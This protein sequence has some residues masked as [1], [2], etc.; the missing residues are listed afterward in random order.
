MM[1]NL[2]ARLGSPM[3]SVALLLAAVDR[4]D[5]YGLAGV[6]LT[7]HAFAIAAATPAAG[8]LV[9]KYGAR[10][11]IAGGVAA[12]TVAY[13]G[14]LLAFAS[15]SPVA[16]IGAV[17]VFG[18]TTPPV[19]PVTRGVLPRL[20]GGDTLVA[21][22]ALDSAINEVA[23]VV[24]PLLVAA[25]TTAVSAHTVVI[26]AGALMLVAPALLVLLPDIGRLGVA[27]APTPSRSRLD[28]IFGPL[29]HRPAL[30]L[31]FLAAFG[32]FGFGALRIA[33]AAAAATSGYVSAAGVLMG[34]LSAGAFLGALGYG[35]LTR[36]FTGRRLLVLLSAAEAVAMLAGFLTTELVGL[37]LAVV[38]IGLLGGA[39]DSAIPALL[40]GDVS[41]GYRTEVFGWLTTFMWLGYGLGTSAAGAVTGPAGDGGPALCLAAAV[42]VAACV[43]ALAVGPAVPGSSIHLSRQ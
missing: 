10:R 34:L 42:S 35:G 28:R 32:T 8:R 20:V 25:M 43:L 11:V 13:T 40:A 14:V 29:T 37:S 17:V 16:L 24:G 4:F 3:L 30:I 5:S 9:D 15:S 26:L 2:V 39:R 23:F 7:A 38:T 27:S 21:A 6:I 36:R 12:N 22:Y 1:L 33:T 41:P 19:G 31:L 18:A